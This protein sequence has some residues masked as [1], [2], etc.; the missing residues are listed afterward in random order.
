MQSQAERRHG[1]W[2]CHTLPRPGGMA[3][4][5]QSRDNVQPMRYMLAGE[6]RRSG[7]VLDGVAEDVSSRVTVHLS[8]PVA[9][10]PRAT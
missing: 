3:A 8:A 7:A 9:V 5:G 4:A 1:D 6:A 10:R 2:H